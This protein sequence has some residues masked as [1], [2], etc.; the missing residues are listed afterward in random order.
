MKTISNIQ[1]HTIYHTVA[2][3]VG[4]A[5]IIVITQYACKVIQGKYMR[6]RDSYA[7]LVLLA[8]FTLVVVRITRNQEC[9]E[10]Q[11]RQKRQDARKEHRSCIARRLHNKQR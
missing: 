1:I 7:F 2:K 5:G 10:S 8:V 3:H 6:G 9:D 11:Q 4:A